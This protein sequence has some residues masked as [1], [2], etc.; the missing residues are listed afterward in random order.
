MVSISH[1]P[2]LAIVVFISDDKLR[3]K[4]AT[5]GADSKFAQP[6]SGLGSEF[7]SDGGGAVVPHGLVSWSGGTTSFS[8]G[9]AK[10]C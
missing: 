9:Q 5:N 7:I 6:W 3:P 2:E 8:P 10:S 1:D 4:L